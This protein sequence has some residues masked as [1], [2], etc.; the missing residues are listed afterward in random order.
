MRDNLGWGTGCEE[1]PITPPRLV[2]D[3]RRAIPE[4]GI[5]CL[6]NGLYKVPARMFAQLD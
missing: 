3:L 5:L 2:A 6:D 1:F 4:D